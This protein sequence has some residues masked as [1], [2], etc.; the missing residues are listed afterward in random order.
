MAYP[1]PV[2]TGT[3][4][5]T[6]PQVNTHP[7][8]H[9]LIHAALTDIINVL[10]SNPAGNAADIASNINLACPV[11]AVLPFAGSAAPSGWVICNGAQVS[12]TAYPQ[13][14]ALIGTT[15]GTGNGSTTFNLPDLRGKFPVGAGG[16]GYADTLA[17]TGG[18][19]HAIIPNHNHS[20]VDYVRNNDGISSP[21]TYGLGPGYSGNVEVNNTYTTGNANAGEA[22]TNKNLPP[23]LALNFIIRAQ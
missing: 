9:N 4:I 15:Y 19:P 7:N 16:S 12:R 17:N 20:Y 22:T 23:Y 10:G 1:P 2:P 6:T 5:N 21:G 18:S 8:D 11:G 14:Y 13:L 3:R